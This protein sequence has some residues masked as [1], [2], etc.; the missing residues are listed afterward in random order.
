[1]V[2]DESGLEGAGV[3]RTTADRLFQ[4]G[5]RRPIKSL[6]GIDVDLL[7]RLFEVEGDLELEG[8]IPED[9]LLVVK[10][11]AFTLN[12]FAAGPVVADKGIL[13]NGNVSGCHL[14]ARQG[15]ITINGSVLSNAQVIAQGGHLT[16]QAA[17]SP[18]CLFGW[19]GVR[20]TG[21]MRG[22]RAFGAAIE[23]AGTGVGVELHATGPIRVTALETGQRGG[24]MVCLRQSITCEDYGRPL[25][26]E[27]RRLIRGIGK[28]IYEALIMGRLVRFANRD[29]QD[30]QRT[31]LYILLG[32]QLNA[33]RVRQLRGL[34]CQ[35]NYA[36][37]LLSIS[38]R[39]L[40]VVGTL[41]RQPSQGALD[42]AGLLS[43]ECT[44][45]LKTLL[46]DVRT[47][48]TIFALEYRG[49]VVS[50]CGE[51]QQWAAQLRKDATL[52]TEWR[53]LH[54][55]ILERRTRWLELNQTLQENIAEQVGQFSLRPD[56]VKAAESQPDKVET[57]LAQVVSKLAEDPA[58]E[59]YERLR[60][61]VV[62]L[63]NTQVE[64]NRKNIQNWQKVLDAAREQISQI[65]TTLGATAA[66]LFAGNLRDTVFVSAER[67]DAQTVILADPLPN[68]DPM[69]TATSIVTLASASGKAQYTMNQGVIQRV[70]AAE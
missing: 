70:S 59:R 57:M 60:S 24:S 20:I 67:Y 53:P 22:G 5:A 19:R 30:S 40:Q 10:G 13:L 64:R 65:H 23:I 14:I 41:V 8:D 29:I 27:E 3:L 56:V 58:S 12:G 2:P 16:L 51:L 7:A 11:G 42:E 61:P 43:S 68:S 28:Y 6:A 50:A 52:K 37:E 21:G 44:D 66:S 47:A 9:A 26:E 55:Q 36:S 38:E 62:R 49:I 46:E 39:M 69:Q 4:G 17:E 25:G 34:Q 33:Q 48:S 63:I 15:D 54:N 18:R 32:G 35:A 45:S 31:V 1:M